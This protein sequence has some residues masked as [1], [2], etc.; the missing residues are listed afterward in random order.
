MAAN[1]FPSVGQR[2]CGHINA[3]AMAVAVGLGAALLSPAGVANA[4]VEHCTGESWP[5][6]LDVREFS[7]QYPGDDTR[8]FIVEV[9]AAMPQAD[10]Q[11]F[12]DRPGE[13]V[14]FRLWGDDPSYDD[15]LSEF[16]PDRYAAT[17]EG[18]WMRGGTI[19][20]ASVAD[21]DTPPD[22]ASSDEWYVGIRLT[23][24]RNGSEHKVETCRLNNEF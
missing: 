9:V 21:E 6:I 13:E 4:R 19:V 12:V 14:I 17:P 22:P 15:Q 20:S 18:L 16:R 3:V 11:L 24:I 2:A 5:G 10:A 23:D 7:L 8:L 1:I